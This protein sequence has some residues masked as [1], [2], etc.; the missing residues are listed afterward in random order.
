MLRRI[1][2]LATASA[3]LGVAI[4][5]TVV[6]ATAVAAAVVSSTTVAAAC[7]DQA[8]TGCRVDDGALDRRIGVCGK[9]GDGYA[10]ES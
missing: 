2:A 6:A 8:D 3:L 10:Q 7:G 5:A 9:C 4:T 1:L